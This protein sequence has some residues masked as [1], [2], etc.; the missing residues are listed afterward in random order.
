MS[1]FRVMSDLEEKQLEEV[2]SVT[3]SVLETREAVLKGNKKVAQVIGIA[4]GG[5]IGSAIITRG[6]EEGILGVI[7]SQE[8][9]NVIL[10][11][12]TGFFPFFPLKILKKRM[13]L[14]FA[15]SKEKK[16]EHLK[17]VNYLKEIAEKMAKIAIKYEERYK[18]CE[19]ISKDKDEIIRK[20]KEKLAEYELI[21][22]IL[23]NK[24][25][26]IESNLARY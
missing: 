3:D 15:R 13:S 17:Q 1:E 25:S 10:G 5:P 20:Q 6:S 11:I 16:K 8:M 7:G 4:L 18:E 9:K 23:K 12:S 26:D 19:R 2:L 24:H 22:N 14:S 21:F